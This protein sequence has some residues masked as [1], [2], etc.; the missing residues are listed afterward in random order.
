MHNIH[1]YT[2]KTMEE[3]FEII[4]LDLI[5]TKDLNVTENL[6]Q[7]YLIEK[8]D[9][10][11]ITLLNMFTTFINGDMDE[12]HSSKF[13]HECI[14]L[15]NSRDAK[16]DMF[17]DDWENIMTQMSDDYVYN[18]LKKF[19][20]SENSKKSY[21]FTNFI[22]SFK[23]FRNVIKK[24]E[25]YNNAQ[26]FA[27]FGIF[28]N[29]FFD[30]YKN[31]KTEKLIKCYSGIIEDTDVYPELMKYLNAI[32]KLNDSY[33]SVTNAVMP[34]NKC[35]TLDF[36][37]FLMEFMNKIYE[38]KKNDILNSVNQN[39]SA[40]V[41]DFN[42]EELNVNNQIYITYL[43]CFRNMLNCA[44]KMFDMK[45]AGTVVSPQ[46]IKIIK[47]ILC[48]KFIEN[49]FCDYV[50]VFKFIKLEE[51][52]DDCI[53]YYDF[54]MTYSDEFDYKFSN[55]FY[56]VISNM[57]GGFDG[58]IKN[59]HTRLNVFNTIK[60]KSGKTGF[61]IYPNFFD[62]LFK[63]IN[64]ID[65][66]KFGFTFLQQKFSH[67]H[68]ITEILLQMCDV[69]S[70]IS[71]KSKYIFPETIY[72]LTSCSFEIFDMFNDKLYDEIISTNISNM[73]HYIECYFSV[74][75][76]ALY[77]ILIYNTIYEK[78]I[79]STIYSE[80]EEKIILFIGRILDNTKM[81]TGNKFALKNFKSITDNLIPIC[82]SFLHKKISANEDVIF[83]IK[84][85]IKKSFEVYE[86]EHKSEI[87]NIIDNY[88]ETEDYPTEFIDPIT[89]KFI[90]NPVMIPNSTEIF[91]RTS[92]V[93]QIYNQGINPYTREKLTLEILED[94]NSKNNIKDKIKIFEEKKNI[95][96]NAK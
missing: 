46:Y 25:L 10:N 27:K 65:C 45:K 82:F 49:A 66:S 37:V 13:V 88:K 40:F 9:E 35:S 29:M 79:I 93:S 96:K 30:N 51:I 60:K 85:Q 6:I 57:L 95:W 76:T 24:F 47:K 22:W 1:Q 62:N 70:S 77:T 17:F 54:M 3:N 75:E 18:L 78:N 7:K 89:C 28:R 61:T 32:I 92:I 63:F 52:F 21:E 87:L 80:L 59:P 69:C 90:K 26:D 68:S 83:E 19:L 33:S 48:S 73:K 20:S 55:K 31:F 14:C 86:F 64:E 44:T 84:E 53:N 50:S 2:N 12:T 58:N 11:K 67:I 16:F 42:I 23:L 15:L 72:R 56:E 4:L 71:E 36:I 5:C 8:S 43:H 74:L 38:K 41:V 34:Q 91:E 39:I 81:K 94:H